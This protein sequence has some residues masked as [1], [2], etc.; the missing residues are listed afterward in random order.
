[1]RTHK[2]GARTQRKEMA[3]VR[4][5]QRK[6]VK[7]TCG[8]CKKKKNKHE[9]STCVT[10]RDKEVTKPARRDEDRELKASDVLEPRT[11]TGTKHFARQ[12]RGLSRIFKLIVSPIEKI[13]VSYT[14]LTLPTKLEV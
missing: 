6:E 13:P 11:E 5:V 3:H 14:H 4:G 10:Y 7:D 2:Q 8:A 9:K 1:M 12:D